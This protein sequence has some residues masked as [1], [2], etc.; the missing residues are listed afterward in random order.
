[1]R[2]EPLVS[3]IIPVYNSARYLGEAVGS[4]LAQTYRPLEVILVDDG[5]TDDSAEVARSFGDAVRL[6]SQANSGVAAARNRGI[7]M[8][9]GELL[10]FLDADDLWSQEK[11]SRQ[12]AV[13]LADPSLDAVFGHVRQFHSPELAESLRQT[14]HYAAEVMPGYHAGTLLIRRGA[15]ERVGPFE[16]RWQ[17]AEFVSWHLRATEA[18]LRMLMLPDV[19]MHRRLHDTNQGL[20]LRHAAVDYVRALKASLDR[21]RAADE[22][23]GRERP[24]QQ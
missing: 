21:R 17:R 14:T 9:A 12:T 11:L 15:F 4:V 3:V 18:G 22:A 19:V 10:A 24:G 7:A 23:G 6:Y 20:R 13:L 8:A 2:A 16:S 5:S 1:M